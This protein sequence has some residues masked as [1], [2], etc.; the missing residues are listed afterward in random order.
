MKSIIKKEDLIKAINLTDPIVSIKNI[1]SSLSNL[2]FDFFKNHI[3]ISSS[4]KELFVKTRINAVCGNVMSCLVNGKKL[5]SILKEL[6]DNDISLDVDENLKMIVTSNAKTI[7]GKYSIYCSQDD[8]FPEAPVFAEENYIEIEQSVL[9]EMIIKVIFASSIDT[10]MPVFNSIYF[11]SDSSG[12]LSIAASDSRRLSCISRKVSE[13]TEGFSMLLP[14]KAINEVL[15]ILDSG[16]C[17][18]SLNMKQF[19]LS[20]ENTFFVSSI[21]DEVFPNY[22]QIIPREYLYEFEIKR[23]DLFNSL[24]RAMIFTKEPANKINLN[25]NSERM[26]ISASTSDLGASEEELRVLPVKE[27]EISL[28]LNGKFLLDSIK[29]IDSDCIRLCLSGNKNPIMVIPKNDKDHISVM[30]PFT[31]N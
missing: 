4:D 27:G 18:I 24:K 3:N 9:K 22:R 17:K 6:P 12:R 15:R 11:E 31:M 29:E 19:F 5:L 10:I 8:D 21:I 25:V 30:M 26:V 7:K 16:V 20:V 28:V 23:I 2:S 14:L 13:N 1:S